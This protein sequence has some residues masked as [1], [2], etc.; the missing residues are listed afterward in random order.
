MAPKAGTQAEDYRYWTDERVRFND[1]DVLGH[2]N[3][4]A[5]AIY[6]E[7]GR[8]GFMSQIGLWV[9]GSHI[10][11]VIARTEMDY[12]REVQFPAQLRIG[13][14]VL[15]IGTRSFT[16]GIGIFKGDDCVLVARNVI[17]RFDSKTR[18]SVPL[19]DEARGLLLP[20]LRANHPNG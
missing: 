19:D 9:M 5:Y 10:A 2:V 11:N 13:V 4:I 14:N 20:Y 12:L 6:V 17:V 15:A 16:L 18:G 3:N 8:A 7:T 1:L